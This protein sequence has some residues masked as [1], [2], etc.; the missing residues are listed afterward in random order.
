MD[1]RT[2]Q[3]LIFEAHRKSKGASYLLWFFLG[4]L[5]AH[6]FY[7]GRTGTGIAQLL[8]C[9][10]VIG[11]IPLAFWWLIDAFRI[12][13]MV[14]DQNME[15]IRMLGGSVPATHGDPRLDAPP[16]RAPSVDPRVAEI[17]AMR[18]R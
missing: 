7:L 18:R 3:Q 12:P 10:S 6:G 13:D 17:R 14:R 1:S 15:T 9:L 16:A 11:I 2:Q 4:F 8:V 5:V